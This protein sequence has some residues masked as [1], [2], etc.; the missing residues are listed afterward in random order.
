MRSAAKSAD[1]PTSPL[2]AAPER[3][4][5]PDGGR[6]YRRF[7]QWMTGDGF[8]M[9]VLE[10][11][12]PRRVNELVAW[13]M[14]EMKGAVVFE[15]DKA[16]GRPLLPLFMEVCPSPAETP[17]L[18]LTRLEEAPER[19]T[20]MARINIQ[21]DELARA[22]PLPWV[23]L[24]HPSAA[25]EMQKHAPDFSD[26]A[27]LWLREE[28]EEPRSGLE[29]AQVRA[30]A[31]QQ[32]SR[33]ALSQTS[34]PTPTLLRQAT[35]AIL[36]G[37]TNEAID[38]LAQ[39][40]LHH[41]NDRAVDPARIRIDGLILLAHEQFEEAFSRFEAAL[42]R[43]SEAE[44]SNLRAALL[45]DIA[46][47]HDGRG[48]WDLALDLHRQA[49]H[50]YETTGDQHEQAVARAKIGDVYAARGQLDEALSIFENQVLP[51]FDRLGDTRA[52]AVALGTIADIHVARGQHDPAFRLL[53]EE[54]LPVFKQLG[55]DRESAVT[56][57]KIADI[58]AARGQTDEALQ[59]LTEQ[60]LPVFQRAGAMRAHA[61]TMDKIADIRFAAGQLDEALRILT[62][63]VLPVYERLNAVRACAVARGT[64]ADIHSAK[65]QNDEALRILTK[66]VLPVYERLGDRRSMA[67]A[68]T[69]VA[70]LYLQR[71]RPEDMTLA[72][73]LLRLALHDAEA[74]KLPEAAQIRSFLAEND[75][76]ASAPPSPE[77]LA[78]PDP[79]SGLPPSLVSR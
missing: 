67:I 47:I 44:D 17:A 57:A 45:L 53:S 61:V 41:P 74:M 29:M 24:V 65:G 12:S 49:L 16:S 21:R 72:A 30:P 26:F 31:Q 70:R 13:T 68:R 66:E 52:R 27:G 11:A 37:R 1:G 75:L 25:L 39:H 8:A 20:L 42:K 73:N 40:D 54:V 32:A 7:L 33:S 78:A 43:C 15:L 71:A 19:I 22:F 48:D 50:I 62:E 60:V 56:T 64:I 51:V 2:L 58:L 4:L 34:R 38:L 59:M 46:S 6:A 63:D 28:V 18:L 10:I 23:V 35:E 55:D 36:R 9:A 76:D 79:T 3:I 69:N 5:G 77:P 14:A